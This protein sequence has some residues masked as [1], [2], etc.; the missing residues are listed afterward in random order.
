MVFILAAWAG[1]DLGDYDG[2]LELLDRCPGD[3][4][5]DPGFR[6][7]YVRYATMSA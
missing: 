6:D 1:A 5:E 4:V 2:A 7:L 3:L